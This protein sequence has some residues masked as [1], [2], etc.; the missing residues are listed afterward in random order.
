H[1]DERW[2]AS[3][4][5]GGQHGRP[6]QRSDQAAGRGPDRQ[7]IAGHPRRT[8]DLLDCERRGQVFRDSAGAVRGDLPA[9]GR[10]ERHAPGQ[11]AERDSFSHRVQRID[12]RRA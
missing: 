9:V 12:H 4:P 10:A 8:D 5:R 2:Y 11:P 6:G 1:G 3:G 7:G